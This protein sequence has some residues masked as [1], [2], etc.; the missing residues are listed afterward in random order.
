MKKLII[1]FLLGIFLFSSCGITN[2]NCD[3]GKKVKSEMW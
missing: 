1:L 2:R 3:G